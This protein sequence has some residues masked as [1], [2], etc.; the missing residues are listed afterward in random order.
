MH[1]VPASRLAPFRRAVALVAVLNLGYFGVE[2]A[3]ALAIGSVALLADSVDFLEDAAVNSL[4]LLALRW[5]PRRR[6][7]LG[8]VLAALL[9]APAV[10]ALWTAWRRIA[11]GEAPAAT[12]MAAA[13]IGAFVVNVFCAF[14]LARFRDVEGSLSK[15]AFLSARNDAIA[16]LAIVAAAGV[17]SFAPSIWPDFVVGIGIAILNAD[18]GKEVWD[19]ARGEH[20]AQ[21]RGKP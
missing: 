19:A 18:A 8:Y 3:V 2:L 1:H 6:A 9:L 21:H 16:N 11:S 15:A 4:I 13:A 7:R 20:H 14:H 10:A 5:S 17:T 12:P